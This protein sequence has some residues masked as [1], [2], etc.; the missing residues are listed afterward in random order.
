MRWVYTFWAVAMTLSITRILVMILVAA[1]FLPEQ[2]SA[3]TDADNERDQLE[4]V[5]G[6]QQI[7]PPWQPAALDLLIPGYGLYS[8]DRPY[9]AMSYAGLKLA[10]AALIYISI[11]NYRFWNSIEKAAAARDIVEHDPLLFQDP[12][13]SEKYMTHQ[14]IKNKRDQAWLMIVYAGIF[15]VL[16]YTVSFS[17]TW[18]LASEKK[19]QVKPFYRLEPEQTGTGSNSA[20]HPRIDAGLQFN[21]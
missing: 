21:F 11:K 10:G 5:R 6:S 20:I 8:H 16:V 1:L 4:Y 19:K 7:T 15:E 3:Y 12:L 18:Y 14:D 13:N 9:W 17:H 2:A